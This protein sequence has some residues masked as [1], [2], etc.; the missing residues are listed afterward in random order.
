MEKNYFEDYGVG[1]VF[2]S[3]G[4]TITETDIVLFS[5]FTGDWHQLHTN[6]EYAAKTPFKERIAHGMLGL[7]VGMA[8]LFRLGPHVVLPKSFIAFYGMEGVRFTAPVKIGDTIHC[9]MTICGL[10]EKD[11]GRGIIEAHNAVKNQRGETVIVFTT[12]IIAGRR[13]A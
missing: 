5:A 10:E 8:L 13:P 1:E 9:E 7:T 2:V 3:P 4:R 12:K 11:G 6:I